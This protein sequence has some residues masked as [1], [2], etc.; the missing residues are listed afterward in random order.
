MAS[1]N[2]QPQITFDEFNRLRILDAEY[3]KHTE[4]L[5]EDSGAFISKL[6]QFNKAVENLTVLM[7]QQAEKL[8][9]EKLKVSCNSAM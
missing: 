2:R 4:H 3:A 8:E 7:N 6:G 9:T 1:K 5:V